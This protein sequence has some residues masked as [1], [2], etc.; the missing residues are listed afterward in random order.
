MGYGLLQIA[1]SHLPNH[2]AQMRATLEKARQIAG[3]LP[4]STEAVYEPAN[5]ARPRRRNGMKIKQALVYQV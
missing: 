4:W 1:T 2:L 3:E 5:E